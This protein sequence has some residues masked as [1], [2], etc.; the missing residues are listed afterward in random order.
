MKDICLTNPN[1]TLNFKQA[2]ND[3]QMTHK[4]AH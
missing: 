1:S 3:F 4:I 2:I